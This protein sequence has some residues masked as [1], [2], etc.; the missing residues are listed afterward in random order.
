M[1]GIFNVLVILSLTIRGL[2]VVA[3]PWMGFL[4]CKAVLRCKYKTSRGQKMALA[5]KT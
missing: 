3:H 2:C 4:A 5:K 1:I